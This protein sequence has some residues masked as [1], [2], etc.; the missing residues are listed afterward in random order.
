MFDDLQKAPTRGALEGKL[1][2]APKGLMNLYALITKRFSETLDEDQLL[3]CRR[4]LQWIITTKEHLTVDKLAV[5]LAI[6]EGQKVLDQADVMFDP[7]EEIMAVCAPLVEIADQTVRIVHLSVKDFL[8]DSSRTNGQDG[9]AFSKDSLNADLGISL[10][11]LLSFDDF[12]AASTSYDSDDQIEKQNQSFGARSSTSVSDEAGDQSDDENESSQASWLLQYGLDNW[13]HHC[14][15]SEVSEN[16]PCLY[17]LVCNYL[18]SDNSFLWMRN[19][20][21]HNFYVD[22]IHIENQ[23]LEW[24]RKLNA[25]EETALRRGFV[26]GIAARRMAHLKKDLGGSNPRTLDAMDDLATIWQ[27][28]GRWKEAEELGVQVLEVRK[29]VL[30]QEHPDTL[31]SMNHLA[32]TWKSLGRDKEAIALMRQVERG[33]REVLGVAHPHTKDS[34]DGLEIWE[35]AFNFQESGFSAEAFTLGMEDEDPEVQGED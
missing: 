14:V 12:S 5:A 33:C 29:R 21:V 20:A 35:I 1:V 32:C 18:K 23:L 2:K 9:F 27:N 11:T 30:G 25:G 34:R 3:L 19:L 31:W 16:A 26:H 6:Q 13:H 17:Q 4:V 7:Q 28:Q 15:E 10:L 24:G 8:L 22:W